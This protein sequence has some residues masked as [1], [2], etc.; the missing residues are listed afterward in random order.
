[1]LDTTYSSFP[2]A[3]LR[4]YETLQWI[5][6]DPLAERAYAAEG[7]FVWNSMEDQYR[8]IRKRSFVDYLRSLEMCA[9]LVVPKR[10]EDGAVSALAILS[11]KPQQITPSMRLAVAVITD[12]AL[13][14]VEMLGLSPR[15]SADEANALR[16]LSEA[17]MEILKWMAEGKSNTDI[18]TITGYSDRSVRHNVSEVLR[19]FGVATRL[20]AVTIFRNS[21]TQI[22]QRDL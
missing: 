21:S 5:N 10:H 3:F 18:A 17:Q 20:Q 2:D 22:C 8:D 1:M 11:L 9:G 16:L 6:V 19:K 7:A 12:A 15:I 14:K 4:D 13:A